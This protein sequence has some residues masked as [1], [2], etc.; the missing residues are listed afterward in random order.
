MLTATTRDICIKDGEPELTFTSPTEVVVVR[1]ILT[2][3]NRSVLD[4]NRTSKPFDT[5]I[6][7]RKYL[8][9]FDSCSATYTT[10]CKTIDLITVRDNIPTVTDRNVANYTRVVCVIGTTEA[11]LILISRNT[12]NVV[13]STW[14]SDSRITKHDQTTPKTTVNGLQVGWVICIISFSSKDDRLIRCTF[15]EDLSTNRNDQSR[16]GITCRRSA[17]SFDHRTR[18][19]I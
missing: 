15:S 6:I 3:G 9:V 10:K 14:A 4:R 8:Y 11:S 5:V 13:C 17:L 18:L 19:D 2:K 12:F 7:V 16:S 1:V